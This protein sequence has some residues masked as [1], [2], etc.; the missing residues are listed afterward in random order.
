MEYFDF[1]SLSFDIHPYEGNPDIY[2]SP[3]HSG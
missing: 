1:N 3:C 2:I